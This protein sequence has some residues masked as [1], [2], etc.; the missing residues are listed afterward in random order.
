MGEPRSAVDGQG[1][2]ADAVPLPGFGDEAGGQGGVL[3][4]GQQPADDCAAEDVEGDVEIEDLPL[5]WS[6]QL[7]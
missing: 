4:F 6:L 5:V 1:S 3:V 7:G 2:R